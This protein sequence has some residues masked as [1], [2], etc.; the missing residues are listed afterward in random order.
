MPEIEREE[1]SPNT[2]NGWL[3]ILLTTLREA[4]TT[5]SSSVIRLGRC[6]LFDTSELAT[7]IEE[8]PNREAA[9]P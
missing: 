5:S 6:R 9:N 3:S 1:Y 8:E 7:F 4:W 2:V